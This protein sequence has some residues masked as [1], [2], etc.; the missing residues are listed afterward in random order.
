MINYVPSFI[1]DKL[2][3]QKPQGSFNGFILD[4]RL[5]DFEQVLASFEKQGKSGA[6]SLTS[7]LNR[8]GKEL[9][10][11]VENRGGFVAKMEGNFFLL[12]FPEVD[13]R[14]VLAAAKELEKIGDE[15]K[16]VSDLKWRLALGYGQIHWRIIMNPLQHRAGYFGLDLEKLEEIPAQAG[17]LQLTAA[18]R[19]KLEDL[20]LLNDKGEPKT[21]RNLKPVPLNIPLDEELAELQ[22][23]FT[24]SRYQY[25]QPQ[26]AFQNVACIH[27]SMG[28]EGLQDVDSII[29]VMEVI[30]IAFK[31]YMFG[32]RKTT[33][34]Y[35]IFAYYGLPFK[36]PDMY[37]RACRF[38]LDVRKKYPNIRMGIAADKVFSTCL[39]FPGG[40][41]YVVFG[42]AGRRAKELWALT[43][44]AQVAVDESVR[45]KTNKT[46]RFHAWQGLKQGSEQV[47]ELA[48]M[49]K[50]SQ[51]SERDIFVGRKDEFAVLE[52]IIDQT[53]TMKTNYAVH[54][55]GVPGIGKTRLMVEA[56]KLAENKGFRVLPACCDMP[57]SPPFDPVKRIF[58]R[59]FEMKPELKEEEALELF[60]EKW[61]KLTRGRKGFAELQ[62]FIA[63]ILDLR[64]QGSPL[65]MMDPDLRMQRV[66]K[67]GVRFLEEAS[68]VEPLLL[69]IDDLQW[70]DSRSRIFFEAL[71]KAKSFCISILASTRHL[72]DGSIP[73]LEIPKFKSLQIELNPLAKKEGL[74]MCVNLLG[75]EELPKDTE[76]FFIKYNDGNP[77]NIGQALALL[78]E[79]GIVN[80]RGEVS[81]PENWQ[82]MGIKK[83]L[84]RRLNRLSAKTRD[85]VVNASVLGMRIN[86]K[87]LS[88]MLNSSP[89]KHLEQVSKS[90]IWKDLDEVF[91]IFSHILIQEAVYST[92]M[93]D[94]LRELHLS[95]AQAMEKV[96]AKDLHEHSAEIA[97]HFEKADKPEQAALYHFKAAEL[98][99]EQS[100]LDKSEQ[101]FLRAV[102]LSEAACGKDS[103]QYCQHRFYLTL[104]YHYQGRYQEAEPIYKEVIEL[105]KKIHGVRSLE[106]SPYLNNLGRFYKDIGR[107]SEA[108]KLLKRSLEMERKMS[109]GS[110][111]VADR[112]NNLA[113]M[114]GK[115]G[116]RDKAIEY[117]ERCL[118]IM[119]YPQNRTHWFL[120]VICDNLGRLYFYEGQIGRAKEL[121]TRGYEIM[122]EKLGDDDPR[123]YIHLISLAQIDVHENQPRLAETKYLK[124]LDFLKG[125]FGHYHSKTLGVVEWLKELYEG[126]GDAD[127]VDFYAK[128]LEKGK[129]DDETDTPKHHKL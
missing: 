26:S 91:Y 44:P 52:D 17:K 51:F 11:I 69:A 82:F 59:L 115:Q 101:H 18:A 36:D 88:E 55:S 5:A 10:R 40:C 94:K 49:L 20:A 31:T 45:T 125:S 100:F 104:L 50:T 110:S 58:S 33:N 108:E 93:A 77:F 62:P 129:K 80:A 89:R 57:V 112:M 12:M 83:V 84:L 39:D 37:L 113:H 76:N 35:S 16:K 68:Q 122:K 102:E 127:E 7:L 25:I 123:L 66:I 64:W 47:F 53:L 1:L 60:G 19:K 9:F 14:Q 116:K 117:L 87:V 119:E 21:S 43:K 79:E 56:L 73:A 97:Q 85:S 63:Y 71:G 4:C 111:N 41:Q 99:W 24:H 13:A 15:E 105:A 34:A 121:V 92:I 38:S 42:K 120:G 65:Y 81:I 95:A 86:I 70:L 48:G 54:I 30:S 8:F 29:Q 75:L 2:R 27:V 107:Y 67:A 96:F 22:E 124:A 128:W 28:L 23:K 90:G 118:V 72:E 61:K 3:Q 126:F 114:Y 32:S 106:L 103:P 98:Y 46:L 6:Q 109:P 78:V 74:K